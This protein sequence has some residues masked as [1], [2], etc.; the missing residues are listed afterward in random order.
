MRSGPEAPLHYRERLGLPPFAIEDFVDR[1]KVR[2]F[3]LM[4][5]ALLE[6]G[7]PMTLGAITLRL[8]EAGADE[9]RTSAYALQKAWHGLKPVYKGPDDRYGLDLDCRELRSLVFD[10]ELQP[11]VARTAPPPPEP[12]P[13][14]SDAP[15]SRPEVD[16]AF[17]GGHLFSVS[18]KRQAAALL[19][20]VGGGPVAVERLEAMMAELAR[21]RHPID[22]KNVCYW[23]G[24]LVQVRPEGLALNRGST[25]LGPMREAIRKLA[26]PVLARSAREARYAEEREVREAE[27]DH[28]L[29]EAATED[30]RRRRALIQVVPGPADIQAAVVM[31]LG[32][33]TITS[34]TASDLVRLTDH[35]AEFDVVIGLQVRDVVITLGQAPDMWR[36]VDL[37]PPQKRLRLNQRGRTLKIY[38]RTADRRDHGHLAAARRSG[39]DRRL[40]R[41]RRREEAGSKA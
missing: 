22:A 16:A 9:D 25:E 36:L 28:T 41:G 14:T 31:D 10:L 27:R 26:A 12:P 35:L 38:P 23:R 8:F 4:V 3:H 29:R 6:H 37:Q 24:D 1:P 13:P 21:Y 32:D 2:P 18:P 19:D 39:E 33:R 34:F 7:A 5:L 20:V 11:R 15:L 40:P 17:R 30:A